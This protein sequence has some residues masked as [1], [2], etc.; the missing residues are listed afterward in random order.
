MCT[1]QITVRAKTDT[2]CAPPVKRSAGL[3]CSAR[4]GNLTIGSSRSLRSLGTGEAGP[5]AKRYITKAI[6]I[7]RT[8]KPTL[9]KLG[10]TALIVITT[11][12]YG[13]LN[14]AMTKETQRQMTEALHG[15]P[16]ATQMKELS[17]IPC[18]RHDKMLSLD[19]NLSEKNSERM[20]SV[21]NRWLTA[22]ILVLI[23]CA[24]IAACIILR[25]KEPSVAI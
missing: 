5:L 6:M 10:A 16:L 7:L 19:T 14:T 18:E 1:S 12:I 2:P 9:A 24:Y 22:N 23:S 20:L 17:K 21:R 15:E 4:L 13:V 25:R 8:L 3:T 11:M